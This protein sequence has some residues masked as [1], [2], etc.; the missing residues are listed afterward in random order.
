MDLLQ[1]CL[2]GCCASSFQKCDAFY[3]TLLSIEK[4]QQQEGLRFIVTLFSCNSRQQICKFL[5]Y[6]CSGPMSAFDAALHIC[7]LTP[8]LI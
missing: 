7:L 6:F 2:S 3:A 8:A 1:S 4:F 5:N